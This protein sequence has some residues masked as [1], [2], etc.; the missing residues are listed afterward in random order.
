MA[1]ATDIGGDK[2]NQDLEFYFEK[3]GVRLFGVL[4][5][6]GKVKP[7]FFFLIFKYKI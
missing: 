3:N 6:H 1:S 7:F 4:D 2:E 5:G